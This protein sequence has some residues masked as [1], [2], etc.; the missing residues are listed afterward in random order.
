MVNSFALKLLTCISTGFFFYSGIPF[1]YAISGGQYELESSVISNGGCSDC[2]GGIYAAKSSLGQNFLPDNRGLSKGGQYANRTGFYNPPRFTFQKGLPAEVYLTGGSVF[3]LP[4]Y[5]VDKRV[6]DITV[7]DDPQN[8]PLNVDPAEIEAAN[9]KIRANEGPWS[10][11]FAGNIKE[12]A[13]FD[14]EDFW[15]EP[16]RESAVLSMKIADSDNDGNVDGTNPPIRLSAV[17]IWRLD[18]DLDMWLKSPGTTFSALSGKF[19]ITASAPGVYALIGTLDDSVKDV[20]AFPVPFRPNGPNAGTGKGQTGTAQSGI[21][22]VN[23]PQKGEIKIYTL[24]GRL[25]K[26]LDIP[27]NLVV[28]KLNWNVKNKAGN[29]VASGV[30]IWTIVSG[31]NSKT[32]KLMIIR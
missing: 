2:R 3:S 19:T 17:R 22:F 25:V 30:Y 23:I 10:S 12:L 1:V 18:R 4:P 16:F 15:N 6:F 21:T 9:E 29:D 11:P 24:D 27:D 20:Y 14:E 5:A 13:I 7:N 32:G 26:K 31:S 8:N 28:S